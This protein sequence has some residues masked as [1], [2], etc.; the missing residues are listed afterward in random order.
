MHNLYSFKETESLSFE[1]PK[2]V[3][4]GPNNSG[5]S[6]VFKLLHLLI[7]ELNLPRTNMY[8]SRIYSDQN[9]P[10]LNVKLSLNR[11]ETN[12]VVGSKDNFPKYRRLMKALNSIDFDGR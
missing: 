11:E 4:V 7:D 1:S 10:C 3:L 12:S 6:N 2:A 8:P 9:R 5:K